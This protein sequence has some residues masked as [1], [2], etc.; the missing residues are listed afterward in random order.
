MCVKHNKLLSNHNFVQVVCS[1]GCIMLEEM[2]LAGNDLKA[3]MGV[4]F[5]T[6]LSVWHLVSFSSECSHIFST[7]C[8]SPGH[9]IMDDNNCILFVDSFDS[10]LLNVW[11]YGRS[12]SLGCKNGVKIRVITSIQVHQVHYLNTF[13]T[14][15]VQNLCMLVYYLFW[16]IQ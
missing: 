7:L 3:E 2:F 14:L 15:K 13:Y 8:T 11:K 1:H 9:E 5:L 16:Q 4:F 6:G 12:F 10:T